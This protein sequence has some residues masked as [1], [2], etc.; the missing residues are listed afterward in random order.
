M[1]DGPARVLAA[2][3]EAG[4]VP[5]SG[6]DLSNR[7][8]VSRAQIWKHVGLLRG[9]GYEIEGAPGG[10]Y[11]LLTTPDRLF[12]EEIQRGLDTAWLGREVH[13][14]DEVDSTN[15]VATSLAQDGAAHGTAVVAES[16]QAGRGRLGRGFFSPPYA[17]LY[18]S[19]VLRPQIDTAATPTLLLAAGL[20]VAEVVAET[21]GTVDDVEIKW[22]NDVLLDGLKTSGILMELATEEARVSHAV[23]GI[24]VNLNVDPATFPDEFR[25][26]ATSLSGHSGQRIDRV[27]FT[28][29]L[30]GRLESVLDAHTQGGLPAIR[31][32]FD[33]FFSMVGR[34]VSIH[35]LGGGV[36][37]GTVLGLAES[38]ALQ[39]T[40]EHGETVTVL[41]GD[42]SLSPDARAPENAHP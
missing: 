9:R 24:G 33:G 11:R 15:R 21:L 30:Y 32:R 38:G 35:Q 18:T 14:F 16:Q 7:L 41:A 20:A 13:Y 12:S 34:A 26:R 22:P 17:N 27:A 23:L 36:L 42:V 1:K 3:H 6:E 8:G 25:D 28:R 29:R 4:D 39:I 10:G 19:I 37:E 31:Q 2:L 40:P 5:C